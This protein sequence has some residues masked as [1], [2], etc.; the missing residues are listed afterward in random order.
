MRT[1]LGTQIILGCIP[2]DCDR[3]R[4]RAAKIGAGNIDFPPPYK[5]SVQD[6]CHDCGGP[7]WVGPE[8]RAQ[9]AKI[10]QAGEDPLILCL[11][12]AVIYSH[13]IRS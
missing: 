10:V 4:L 7:V 11:I 8:I 1:P 12:C 3:N 13:T 6:N 5:N 2:V 9:R